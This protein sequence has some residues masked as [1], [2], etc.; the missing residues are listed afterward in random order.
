MR[1]V[2]R[3]LCLLLLLSLWAI[4]TFGENEEK[5]PIPLASEERIDARKIL[6]FEKGCYQCYTAGE[7]NLPGSELDETLLIGLRG[8]KQGTSPQDD[9]ARAILNPQ[10]TVSPDYEKAIMNLGDHFWAV[11]SPMLGFNNTLTVSNLVHLTTFI[12][13]LAE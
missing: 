5:K 11:N 10:H 8:A 12:S 9:F 1:V 6:F 4:P 13:S 3:P 7:I 2:P